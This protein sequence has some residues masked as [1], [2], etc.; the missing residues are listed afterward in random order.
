MSALSLQT[1]P[2]EVQSIIYSYA[3]PCKRNQNFFICKNITKMVSKQ[4][5]K[6]KAMFMI[7]TYICTN[8]NKE[9]MKFLKY[10][11]VAFF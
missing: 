3:F 5:K 2:E 9:T 10:Y 7:N 1:L 6:C 11:N 4:N 8:C